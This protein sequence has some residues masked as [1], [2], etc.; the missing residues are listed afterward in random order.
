MRGNFPVEVK[1]NPTVLFNIVNSYERRPEKLTRVVGTLLGNNIQGVVEVTDCF[2]VP[3]RE[4]DEVAFD[5]EFA[6]NSF[7]AYKKVNPAVSIVGWYSTGSDIPE[8]SCL[9]HEYYT[10]VTDRHAP[11]HVIVDTTLRSDKPEVKAF[12]SM[13]IGVPSEKQG[14][15][16]APIPVEIISYEPERLAGQHLYLFVCYFCWKLFSFLIFFS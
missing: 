5:I 6:K 11:V 4:G 3:H 9:I 8:S 7:S 1:I 14:S 13:D 10:C 2:V 12:C 16:F 15:L